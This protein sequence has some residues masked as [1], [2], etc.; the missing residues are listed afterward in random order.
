VY[1]R[2]RTIARGVL[3]TGPRSRL[4][5]G[6]RRGKVRFL[7]VASREVVAPAALRAHLRRAGL[8]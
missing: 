1:P 5:V 8:G 2:G 6:V 4:L 3:R 7:A